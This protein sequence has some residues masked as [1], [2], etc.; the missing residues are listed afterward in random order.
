MRES[1][2]ILKHDQALD[3]VQDR[4]ISLDDYYKVVRLDEQWAKEKACDE[5]GL[6]LSK[7][8]V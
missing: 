8:K 7:K 6:A 3:H 2:A 5:A 4:L 1:L